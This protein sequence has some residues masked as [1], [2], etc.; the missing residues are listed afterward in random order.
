MGVLSDLVPGKPGDEQRILAI[1]VPSE[2]L[3]GIDIKG[4]QSLQF[5]MLHEV[6]LGAPFDLEPTNNDDE[7]PW[8]FA[9]PNALTA[10]L[11]QLEGAALRDVAKR[12][13]LHSDGGPDGPL[14]DTLGRICKLA[15]TTI[16]AHE[17]LF[18]W[19]SL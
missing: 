17:E 1:Q 10:A 18:L 11:A 7:G 8:V 12:W 6:V 5:E 4:I 16:K 9:I 2:E 3:G 13:A 19:M 15:K 14:D